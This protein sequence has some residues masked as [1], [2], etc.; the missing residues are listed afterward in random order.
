VLA[1]LQTVICS[2]TQ[3]RWN[4]S[5]LPVLVLIYN[6]SVMFSRTV[7]QSRTKDQ[8]RCW[9]LVRNKRRLGAL[10]VGSHDNTLSFISIPNFS[11][12]PSTDCCC[13][14]CCRRCIHKSIAVTALLTCSRGFL[15]GDQN[16]FTPVI[17][18]LLFR[19]FSRFE[20]F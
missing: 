10:H 8:S 4:S 7:K 1:V 13:C 14:C 17:L 5:L 16:Y 18:P 3:W 2:N 9:L 20:A 11:T 6:I 19:I 15:H 12:A